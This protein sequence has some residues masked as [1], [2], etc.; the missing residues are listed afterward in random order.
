MKVKILEDNLSFDMVDFFKEYKNMIGLGLAS[1]PRDINTMKFYRVVAKNPKYIKPK[2]GLLIRNAYVECG[3][4]LNGLEGCDGLA[5][6]T[7]PSQES[8]NGHLLLKVKGVLDFPSKCLINCSCG[9]GFM[10]YADATRGKPG[11]CYL[12]I[13]TVSQPK[14]T[15]LPIIPFLRMDSIA[16]VQF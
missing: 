12:A 9:T 7:H 6:A 13:V 15:S 14:K 2:N 5:K 4:K 10:I 11:E 3:G 16:A 8:E 1:S